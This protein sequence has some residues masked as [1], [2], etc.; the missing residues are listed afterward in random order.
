[1]NFVIEELWT[2]NRNFSFH[3]GLSVAPLTDVARINFAG[4]AAWRLSR[5]S[6]PCMMQLLLELLLLLLLLLPITLMVLLE[7][8][9]RLD[10]LEGP[11]WLVLPPAEMTTF[12]VTTPGSLR[13]KLRRKL[14][15]FFSL[16]TGIMA[17]KESRRW[18]FDDDDDGS[19]DV[20]SSLEPVTSGGGWISCCGDWSA[21]PRLPEQQPGW[22]PNMQYGSLNPVITN[23][24][25]K[26]RK[27]RIFY[28]PSYRRMTQQRQLRPTIRFR[29]IWI[30][31][32]DT[33]RLDPW[34]PGPQLR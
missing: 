19:E 33:H 5:C 25:K 24:Q 4:S 30:G 31:W 12:D 2:Y 9:V 15:C 11:I 29:F 6:R 16:S 32:N 26:N 17:T 3:L 7:A 13:L 28:N 22:M 14:E 10:R 18:S 20:N 21:D 1:M 23:S 27:N 8:L 34:L